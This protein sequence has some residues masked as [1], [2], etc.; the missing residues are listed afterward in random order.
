MNPGQN[1]LA[2]LANTVRLQRDAEVRAELAEQRHFEA[3]GLDWGAVQEARRQAARQSMERASAERAVPYQP[4]LPGM[5]PSL[6]ALR[7]RDA[8]T[9]QELAAAGVVGYGW[10]RSPEPVGQQLEL[11]FAGRQAA[12]KVVE[13]HR[14]TAQ[15]A[16]SGGSPR[17]AGQRLARLLGFSLA[18]TGGALGA[19]AGLMEPEG[20]Y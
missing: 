3:M 8:L 6:M 10:Q 5:N 19:V 2:S 4:S 15:R 7:S 13:L 16:I 12:N 20:T 11:D 1:P 9:P 14:P 17:F 18:G